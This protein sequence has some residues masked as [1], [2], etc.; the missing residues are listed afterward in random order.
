MKDVE[1]LARQTGERGIPVRRDKQHCVREKKVHI[2]KWLVGKT[3]GLLTSSPFDNWHGKDPRSQQ[4]LAAVLENRLL[5]PL[6][7]PGPVPLVAAL[8]GSLG[9]VAGWLEVVGQG[10]HGGLG[11]AAFTDGA[12]VWL[13]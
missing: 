8:L 10:A 9:A 1:E 4:R 6:S 7:V 13:Y 11:E 5:E 3:Q 12:E 2:W